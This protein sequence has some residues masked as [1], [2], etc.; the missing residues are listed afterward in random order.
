M[1]N[2]QI[3]LIIKKKLHMKDDLAGEVSHLKE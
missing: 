1:Y 3:E 2:K